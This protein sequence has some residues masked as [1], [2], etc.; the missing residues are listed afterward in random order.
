VPTT[1]KPALDDRITQCSGVHALL[2]LWNPST[3]DGKWDNQQTWDNK[4]G[5][6]GFDNR[7]GWDNWDKRKR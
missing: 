3:V 2:D 5:G 4:T 6:G 7:P 1:V